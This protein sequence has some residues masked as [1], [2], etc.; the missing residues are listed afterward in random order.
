MK[1]TDFGGEVAFSLL[2]APVAGDV[3]QANGMNWINGLPAFPDAHYK[4]YDREDPV[5]ETKQIVTVTLSATVAANGKYRLKIGSFSNREFEHMGVLKPFGYTAPAVLTGTAAT[6]KHNLYVKLAKDINRSLPKLVNAYP[7]VTLTHAAG[8]FVVGEVLTGATTGAKGIVVSSS[9]GTCTVALTTLDPYKIFTGTENLDDETGT[10]PFAMS[11]ITLGVGLRLVDTGGY[12]DPKEVK[13]GA[14]VVRAE[15]GFVQG[16]VVITTAAVYSRGQGAWLLGRVPV[17]ERTSGN[18]A[19]G[20]H[21]M[22]VNN[23]P[24]STG[25]YYKYKLYIETPVVPSASQGHTV[26]KKMTYVVWAKG[27]GTVGS[28][29][30][31]TAFN[32][33]I[34]A[35]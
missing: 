20:A 13:S 23:S 2:N 27:G 17:L 1:R 18:L 32:A 6:D 14:T 22:A 35:L 4:G 31:P 25:W 15:T 16:D 9:S 28:P 19:S 24:D 7:L 33:A 12:F 26:T 11:G 5:A 10:G 21:D 29:T 34:A 8:T 3:A 30:A